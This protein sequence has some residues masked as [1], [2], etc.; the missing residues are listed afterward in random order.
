MQTFVDN[1]TSF[2]TRSARAKRK[3]WLIL[4]TRARKKRS[5]SRGL[6]ATTGTKSDPFAPVTEI[7]SSKS[8]S[9]PLR[10]NDLGTQLKKPRMQNPLDHDG[11]RV[12]RPAAHYCRSKSPLSALRPVFQHDLPIKQATQT[13]KVDHAIPKTLKNKP[14][15]SPICTAAPRWY[16]VCLANPDCGMDSATLL[17]RTGTLGRLPSEAAGRSS[18]LFL[19]LG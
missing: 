12:L 17:P 5:K 15:P 4:H 7:L 3:R 6:R 11:K 18:P 2:Q 8:K 1:S 13:S 9:E 14:K 19:G 10:S 16:S